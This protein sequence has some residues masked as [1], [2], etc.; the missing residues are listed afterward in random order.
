MYLARQQL[1][2][3]V[4]SCNATRAS[5]L[6]GGAIVRRLALQRMC[7]AHRGCVNTIEFVGGTEG[8]GSLL[9]S[10]SDD[11]RVAISNV[12][13]GQVV[14]RQQTTH[15]HNI[16]AATAVPHRPDHVVTGAADGE[17]HLVNMRERR[18]ERELLRCNSF[19][20][21]VR[22]LPGD[23]HVLVASEMNGDA[24]IIDLREERSRPLLTRRVPK[25]STALAFDP[26]RPWSM[27]Y[28]G[29][30]C[31][32]LYDLRAL[33]AADSAGESEASPYAR[34][35]PGP[36]MRNNFNDGAFGWETCKHRR[37]Q[38]AEVA[39]LATV[40]WCAA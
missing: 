18:N 7:R 17:I 37:N 25:G 20:T 9:L 30:R 31:V 13:T 40:R 2:R 10:G 22:F 24:Y 8:D 4:T 1:L 21:A 27:A 38:T 36:A 19:A 23:A 16:F 26:R 29:G 28:S 33:S 12:W 15:A 6:G 32:A 35:I 5:L 11:Q 14:A 34:Y 3:G 39:R